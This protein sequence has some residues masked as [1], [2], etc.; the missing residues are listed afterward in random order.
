MAV[1]AWFADVQLST[2]G[3]APCLV[4]SSGSECGLEPRGSSL[5]RAVSSILHRAVM[6]LAGV[7]RAVAQRWKYITLSLGS[8]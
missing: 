8:S 7:P 2:G 6:S 4:F 1:R 3:C 5:C